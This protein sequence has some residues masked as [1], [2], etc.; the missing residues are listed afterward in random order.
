VKAQ[1]GKP[2]R[3]VYT[4]TPAGSDALKAWLAVPPAGEP[5]RSAL[6]LKLFFGDQI[7]PRINAEHV[8][9]VRDEELERRT[10]YDAVE[11]DIRTRHAGAAGSRY[12]LATL[13]YG[14]HRSQAIVNWAD[15][16]LRTLKSGGSR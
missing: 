6:L 16:T 9:R 7:A 12:W 13:S 3:L 2:D 14:R 5:F 4:I 8:A 15:E 1:A 11:R 10:H